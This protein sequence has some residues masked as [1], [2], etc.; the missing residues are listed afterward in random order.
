MTGVGTRQAEVEELPDVLNVL[1]AAALRVDADE[2]KR[3]LDEGDVLVA[4]TEGRVLGTLVLDGNRI[5]AVAVRRSRRG[6]G[7]GTALVETAADR[8][9]RLVAEFDAGVRPFWESVGFRIEPAAEPG[10]YRGVLP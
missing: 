5:V 3:R 6:Q 10:R 8:H 4:A 2:L 7:I 1:D 9:T